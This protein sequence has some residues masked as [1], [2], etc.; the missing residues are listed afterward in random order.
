MLETIVK[1]QLEVLFWTTM[2]WNS[3]VGLN[4]DKP[5]ALAQLN[6]SQA[7]LKRVMEID[8][9]YFFGTPYI[10]MGAILAARPE[11]L[12]GDKVRAKEYFDRAIGLSNGEFFLAQYYFAKYYAVRVQDKKLFIELIKEVESTPPDKLKEICLINAV[13]KQKAK[14]LLDMS[15]ELFL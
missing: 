10:L 14:H 9:D 3:W 8:G 1:E 4:L 7:C 13:I 11:Y 2:A 15:D 6:V 5:V 12:G